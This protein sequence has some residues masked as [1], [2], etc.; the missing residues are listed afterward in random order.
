MED[1]CSAILKR[2]YKQKMARIIAST[3]TR[4]VTLRPP[5]EPHGP[6]DRE[7]SIDLAPSGPLALSEGA[8]NIS[9]EGFCGDDCW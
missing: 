2:N 9:L 4:Y 3:M 1:L 6:I 8:A 7:F 5:D